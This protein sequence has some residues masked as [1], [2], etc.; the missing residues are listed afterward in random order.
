MIV[1]I[2]EEDFRVSTHFY[3]LIKL[4]SSASA[5]VQRDKLI[6]KFTNDGV[7]DAIKD[8]A[9]ALVVDGKKNIEF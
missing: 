1:Q 4:G 2:L 6:E 9:V 7:L 3:S 8:K 5:A